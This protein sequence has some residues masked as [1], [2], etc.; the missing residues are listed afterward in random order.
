MEHGASKLPSVEV[1]SY[2]L[3]IKEE[4][5]FVGDRARRAVFYE[6][7]DELRRK[8]ADVGSDP[9]GDKPTDDHSKK[10]IDRLLIKGEPQE[11]GLVHS[12]VEAFSQRLSDVIRR[13][14]EEDEWKGVEK[15]ALGG[16]MRDSR[17]G[18]LIAGR[19]TAML[20]T[21]GIPV[22]LVPVIYDSDHAGLVGGAYVVPLDMLTGCDVL[23]SVDIGG[24]NFRA[25]VLTLPQKRSS[26][27][28]NIEVWK[29]EHWEYGA[30]AEK[31]SRDDAV[32]HIAK[33]L[34][35]LAEKAEAEE[36]KVASVVCVGCP[37]HIDENGRILDG[38]QNLPGNWEDENFNLPKEL[39][40]AL[41]KQA[42][43][44]FEIVLH[45]DAVL[46]GLS[47][48]PLMRGIERWGVLTIGTGLGNAS[49]RNR[50]G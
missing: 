35:S 42:G 28:K 50:K 30:E 22:E 40:K 15:I 10:D 47:A 3:E 4:G 21:D 25:G 20:K 9:L 31:P 37:G 43:R 39:Q 24:S 13:F 17:V 16:G 48:L 49:F 18:E 11:A 14:L 23:L 34:A 5:K 27:M 26:T 12:A 38:A 29:L 32:Q 46:Q 36:L 19:T 6:I 7:I 44:K 1:L 41:K 2:S 45:N 33:M 8:L